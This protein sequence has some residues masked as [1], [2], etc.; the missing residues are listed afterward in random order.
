MFF[1]IALVYAAVGLGGGS[2]Y[3]AVLAFLGVPYHLIPSTTLL[4]N[5]IVSSGAFYLYWRAG[6]L[7]PQLLLPFVLT[8]IPAAFLSGLL[9]ISK[10]TFTLLLGLG[11]LL[12]ALRMFW[13]PFQQR[14]TDR[15]KMKIWW[16]GL[17]LGTALGIL[18]GL[19]GIGGG[20]LLSPM[21]LLLGW[22]KPKEASAVASAF[23]FLNS[24]SGLVAHSLKGVVDL[25]ILLPAGIAALIGGQLGARWGSHRWSGLTVQRAFSII[26]LG[27]ALKLFLR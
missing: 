13:C 17:P 15:R 26:L 11:L 1:L 25:G 4:L 12:A 20:V 8:S 9:P 21:L 22:A 16:L 3:L 19:V 2:A 27:V 14:E 6:H 7:R 10:G 18:A 23:V 24:I 5:L